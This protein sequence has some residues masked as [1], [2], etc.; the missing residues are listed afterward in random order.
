VEG[1]GEQRSDLHAIAAFSHESIVEAGRFERVEGVG[2]IEQAK[3]A[4]RREASST[5]LGDDDPHW[6]S[7]TESLQILPI[8]GQIRRPAPEFQSL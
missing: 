7:E 6:V 2:E 8:A 5:R 3:R 1:A 4:G